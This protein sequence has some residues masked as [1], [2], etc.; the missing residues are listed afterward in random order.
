[1]C[2]QVQKMQ[3]LRVVEDIGQQRGNRFSLLMPQGG[4]VGVW[5][6]YI[7][8]VAVLSQ[9]TRLILDGIELHS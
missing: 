8:V 3:G 5:G 2:G 6:H 4:E 1:M 7:Y 9:L